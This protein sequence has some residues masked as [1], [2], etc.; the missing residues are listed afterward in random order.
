MAPAEQDRL[1]GRRNSA[2]EKP[3]LGVPRAMRNLSLTVG[4]VAVGL[5]AGPVAIAA[6]DDIIFTATLSPD[7]QS[8]PTDSPAT[9]FA[10]VRLERETLKITWKV[11]YQDTTSPVIAAGLHGPENAG[12]NAGRLVDLAPNGDFKSPI[13]GSTVL[14]DGDFQY[15]ITTRVYV[16]LM[17]TTYKEGELRGHLRRQR[18]APK[19]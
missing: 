18:A 12:A 4:I 13:T 8:I 19:K 5:L 2:N 16:N 9:G 10:E 14:S 15:L 17:T 7:E 6:E 3:I 1:P 11:T